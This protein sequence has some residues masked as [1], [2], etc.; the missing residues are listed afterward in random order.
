MAYL[1]PC[2]TSLKTPSTTDARNCPPVMK[3]T[4]STTSFPRILAGEDSA[5]YSG[6]DIEERPVGRGCGG[7]WGAMCDSSKAIGHITCIAHK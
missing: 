3:A 5:M 6:T 1:H 4:L 7:G 2:G